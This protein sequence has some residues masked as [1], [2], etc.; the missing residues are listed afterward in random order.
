MYRE[1]AFLGSEKALP[2][3][4]ADSTTIRSRRWRLKKSNDPI[5]CKKKKEYDKERTISYRTRRKELDRARY[6][7]N[8]N[9]PEWVEKER[10]KR[11]QYRIVNRERINTLAIVHRQTYYE[12]HPG[13]LQAQLEA[14][15]LWG[16]AN[17]ER[18]RIAATLYRKLNKERIRER[19]KLYRAKKK[20]DIKYM[21]IRRER[22]RLI[23][24]MERLRNPRKVRQRELNK[25][26]V[27]RMRKKNN[28]HE[29]INLDVVYEN[30]NGL[31]GICNKVLGREE[32]TID[33]KLAISRGGWHVYEN[34][35]AAHLSCNC[36]KGS[37]TMEEIATLN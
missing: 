32:M 24:K 25:T 19:G 20:L 37:K 28:P 9:N 10:G 29:E 13:K 14:L 21:A 33:H 11:A 1:R 15:R 6:L 5:W 30:S 4:M 31:C 23:K 3:K 27:R 35:Q 2:K 7:R 12:K 17:K 36:S 16:I 18:V 26:Y 22:D 34:I 8:K